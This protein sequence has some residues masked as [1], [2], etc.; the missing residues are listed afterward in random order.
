MYCTIKIDSTCK[1]QLTKARKILK[2]SEN[3]HFSI[4]FLIPMQKSD[5]LQPKPKTMQKKVFYYKFPQL[6]GDP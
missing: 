5:P 3:H 1:F 4:K 6:K 2:F